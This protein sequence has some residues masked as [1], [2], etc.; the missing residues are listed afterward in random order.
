[1]YGN[2]YVNS[3]EFWKKTEAYKNNFRIKILLKKTHPHSRFC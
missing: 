3:K 1:M 2:E